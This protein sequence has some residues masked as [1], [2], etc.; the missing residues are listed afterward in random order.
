MKLNQNDC[1]EMLI[2]NLK[3]IFLIVAPSFGRFSEDHF[4]L[5]QYFMKQ[6][7]DSCS[8]FQYILICNM[9]QDFE[10]S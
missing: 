2:T 3:T 8:V 6:F 9:Q 1:I 5:N 10:N 4:R 7:S